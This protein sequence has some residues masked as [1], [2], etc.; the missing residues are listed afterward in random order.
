[1]GSVRSG[2]VLRPLWDKFESQHFAQFLN[3]SIQSGIARRTTS[4]ADRWLRLVYVILGIGVFAFLTVLLLPDQSDL[5]IRILRG[6]GVFGSGLVG[7]YGIRTY[8]D[9]RSAGR[10]QSY[11]L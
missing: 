7:G 3:Q 6:L 4:R 10:R 8:Q 11:G 2:H 1:M 9:M 5:Y